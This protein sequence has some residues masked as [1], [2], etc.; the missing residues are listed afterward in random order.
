ME[1]ELTESVVFEDL[2]NPDSILVRLQ[3]LGFK[4]AIDDFGTGYSSLAYLRRMRCHKLK[5]DRAFVRDIHADKESALLVESVVRVAH[6]LGMLVVAEGVEVAQ[7]QSA[8]AALDCDLFQGFGL[9]RPQ[10]VD[11]IDGL[12]EQHHA[13]RLCVSML[14]EACAA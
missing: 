5:L 12:L 13:G 1:F 2:H 14:D 6:A 3:S 9:A 8:L 11:A 10:F 4:L 7:E